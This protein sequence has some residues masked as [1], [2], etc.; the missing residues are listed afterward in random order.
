MRGKAIAIVLL[1]IAVIFA[2]AALARV[3]INSVDSRLE[4]NR[5]AH[6]ITASQFQELRLGMTVAEVRAVVER[7]PADRR[8]YADEGLLE[9]EPAGST[10]SYYD[11]AG[12][13]F[14]SV[15]Q[16]CFR[17][18]RLRSKLPYRFAASP[19]EG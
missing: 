11:I 2:L 12:G 10:C 3:A 17:H 14:G 19:E 7:G 6:A 13:T 18:G 4:A 1:A 9:T 16:L 15:F 8:D 5:D